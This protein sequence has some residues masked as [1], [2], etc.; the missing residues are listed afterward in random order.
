MKSCHHH[1]YHSQCTCADCTM[2]NKG[3]C[4][5][6]LESNLIFIIWKIFA[7]NTD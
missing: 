7:E 5:D 6:S 3:V 1:H 2:K 4:D